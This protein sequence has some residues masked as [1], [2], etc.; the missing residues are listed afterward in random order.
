M[1]IPESN[2]YKMD[3]SSPL[4]EPFYHYTYGGRG[5]HEGL[6]EGDRYVIVTKITGQDNYVFANINTGRLVSGV[7]PLSRFVAI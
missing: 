7:H 2:I 4:N 5:M 6:F 3:M 1:A